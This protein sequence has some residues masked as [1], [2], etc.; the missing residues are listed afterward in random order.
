M[1]GEILAT[2]PFVAAA[3]VRVGIA[4]G[5]EREV[6]HLGGG[7]GEL[8]ADRIKRA[9][10]GA[11]ARGGLDQVT[12]RRQDFSVNALV[13]DDIGENH[14]RAV[15]E[16]LFLVFQERQDDIDVRDDHVGTAFPDE[17][18]AGVLHEPGFL[19]VL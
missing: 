13:G 15:L 18:K 16:P 12:D 1:A 17:S 10:G 5:L 4:D 3:V 14:E 8:L 2:D 6:A 11:L 9:V 7:V 19:A